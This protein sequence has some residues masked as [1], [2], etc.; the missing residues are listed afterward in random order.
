[1]KSLKEYLSESKK[2]Y[3]FKIGV[4]GELPEDFDN[5]LE[6]ALK[7]YGLDNMTPGKKT[8]IQERP[9]DF[10]D[11]ENSEVTYYEV[12]VTYPTTAQVMKEYVG[13]CCNIPA[14]NIVVRNPNEPEEL[15]QQE[16]EDAEYEVKL[17]QEDMGGESAQE[18]AGASR[19]MDLLKELEASRKDR[20]NDY[21]GEAPT[22]DSKD[23]GDKQNTKAVVGG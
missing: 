5:K 8:P 7:K 18:S 16:S 20:E 23:I 6:T 9:L 15:Y 4:A 10:P 11:I 17:T 3:S 22:G 12:D 14:N 2:V 1:M 13:S 21:V 19:V